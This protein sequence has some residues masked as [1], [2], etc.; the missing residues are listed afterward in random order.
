MLLE[1][2]AKTKQPLS[3][4]ISQLPT[5]F[6]E[7]RKVE[8]PDDKKATVAENIIKDTTEY[9]VDTTDGVKVITSDGWVIIRPSG[10]EPIYRC[11]SEA[12]TPEK[13]TE[14]ADWGMNL[15]KKYFF[16]RKRL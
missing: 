10:T 6:S 15:I 13:A 7:K 2:I 1:I 9:E 14:L 11:F 3:Q 4:L 8:C 16:S 5:Y 12:K